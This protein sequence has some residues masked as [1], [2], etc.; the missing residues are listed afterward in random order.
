M[1][2]AL[3]DFFEVDG[4]TG[5][6]VQ[7]DVHYGGASK[8]ILNIELLDGVAPATTANFLNYVNRGDY[9]GVIF[10]RNVP[11]FVIQGGGFEASVSGAPVAIPADPAVVN[12]FNVS[13][14]RGTLAMAKLGTSPDSATNQFFFNL[15]DNSANLDNQNGGF[16]V[17]ARSIGNTI[18]E[19]D[20]LVA[21]PTYNFGGGAFSA[22]PLYNYSPGS[23]PAL[24]SYPTMN[25][26]R[27]VPVHDTGSGASVLTYSVVSNS[28]P[29]YVS[30][31]IQNGSQLVVGGNSGGGVAN[32]TV[33]A[34]DSHG[35]TAQSTFAV[36]SGINSRFVTG[37]G[38]MSVTSAYD[39]ASPDYGSLVFLDP[40]DQRSAYSFRY[41]SMLF[42]LPKDNVV[43][44]FVHG[45]LAIDVP[46]DNWAYTSRADWIY[47]IDPLNGWVY[48]TAHG[49]LFVSDSG[50]EGTYYSL[51]HNTWVYL[52]ETNNVYD[53]INGFWIQ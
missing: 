38:N 49:W 11:G 2:F 12:E 30:A 14:L 1:T 32:I 48:S 24:S 5:P 16:T 15:A 7:L 18:S 28:N 45:W 31:S 46:G 26:A 6:V 4:V 37:F 8:H 33:R 20:T 52:T 53:L 21:L 10:H 35:N 41:K 51:V 34:T 29:G 40:G 27:V 19:V 3:A 17:F 36:N 25:T 43:Y 39:A 50:E 42:A 47:T 13:N 22:M 23:A 9:D 44:S